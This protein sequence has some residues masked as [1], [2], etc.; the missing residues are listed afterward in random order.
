MIC[1]VRIANADASDVELE[2]PEGSPVVDEVHCHD[3]TKNKCFNVEEWKEMGA[4]I[5]HYHWLYHRD[6]LQRQE[7]QKL[8]SQIDIY[9]E[10]IADQ[11]TATTVVAEKYRDEIRRKARDKTKLWRVLGIGGVVVGIIGGA[12][13]VGAIASR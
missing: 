10:R 12:F 6:Q 13:G 4:L 8:R 7:L 11:K 3:M 5:M 9:E 1:F 2:E